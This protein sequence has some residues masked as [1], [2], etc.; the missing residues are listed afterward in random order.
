MALTGGQ[1]RDGAG[2]GG[3]DPVP[4]IPHRPSSRASRRRPHPQAGN[5]CAHQAGWSRARA[6][7]DICARTPGAGFAALAVTPVPGTADRVTG[8][9]P[10]HED[11]DAAGVLDPHPGQPPRFRCGRPDDRAC[12]RGQPDVPGAGIPYLD[13]DHHRAPGRAGRVPGPRAIPGLGKNTTPGSSGGRA[14]SRQPGLT[15]RQKRRVRSRSP[16]RRRTRQPRTSTPLSRH[17]VE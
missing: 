15:P 11:P 12:G 13:P 5:P 3:P 10:G 9:N 1:V 2:A 17:H 8:G 7:Q 4:R 16:G 14:P 6:S